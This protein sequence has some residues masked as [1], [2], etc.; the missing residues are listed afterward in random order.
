MAAEQVMTAEQ[1]MAASRPFFDQGVI[2]EMCQREAVKEYLAGSDRKPPMIISTLGELKSSDVMTLRNGLVKG[3]IISPK[4]SLY[5]TCTKSVQPEYIDSQLRGIQAKIGNRDP[6]TELVVL[7]QVGTFERLGFMVIEWGECD[8][9]TY[10]DTPALKLICA[11]PGFGDILLYT[12]VYLLKY[13]RIPQGLLE[14]A[15]HYHNLPGLC[16]YNKFGFR[17]IMDIKQRNCFEEDGTLPMIVKMDNETTN[18][19]YFNQLDKIIKKDPEFYDILEE[20]KTSEP[21]CSKKWAEKNMKHQQQAQIDIRASIYD[22]MQNDETFKDHGLQIKEE[23]RDILKQVAQSEPGPTTRRSTRRSTRLSSTLG[24]TAYTKRTASGKRNVDDRKYPDVKADI[25]K[26]K[27]CI[28][29]KKKEQSKRTK[30]RKKKANK[31]KGNKNKIKKT[32]RKK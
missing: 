2:Q 25:G 21:L 11:N 12:Y 14:L 27:K 10:R 26:K 19:V 18:D 9:E 22:E 13:H 31:S 4:S 17:E 23:T 32:K 28:Y 7:S 29:N 20:D 5:D 8:I 6:N 1:I 15:G 16:A 3:P 30:G 24:G